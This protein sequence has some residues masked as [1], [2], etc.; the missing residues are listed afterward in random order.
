MSTCY[1]FV[2]DNCREGIEIGSYSSFYAFTF[3]SGEPNCMKMLNHFLEQHS[4][5]RP[6]VRLTNEAEF[7]DLC[8]ED[9]EKPYKEIEW[10]T[11]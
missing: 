1:F 6:H 8:D 10:S 3:Y 7:F 5:C 11:K 9:E 4:S 2:C